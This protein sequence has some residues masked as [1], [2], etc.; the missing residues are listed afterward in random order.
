M[1]VL[2]DQ[3]PVGDSPWNAELQDIMGC[4][5][6]ERLLDLGVGSIIEVN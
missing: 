6:I 1:V 3:V 5:D 2:F 4:L